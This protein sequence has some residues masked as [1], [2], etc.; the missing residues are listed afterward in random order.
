MKTKFLAFL[1]GAALVCLISGAAHAD[2]LPLPANLIGY[3]T[4][5][6]NA[7]DSSATGNNGSFSGSYAAGINGQSFNLATGSVTI[8][9]NTAYG[10]LGSG[11]SAGFRFNFNGISAS[12][13]DIIGQDVGP[14]GNPKW[15]VFYDYTTPGFEL[16]INGPSTAFLTA[17]AVPITPGWHQ[18]TVTD[19]GGNYN[20]YLDGS[21]IGSTSFGGAF[22]APSAPLEFGF[23]DGGAPFPG[24]LE[25]VVLYNVALTP[26]EVSALG[27]VPEPSTWAMMLL[28]FAGLGFMAYRRKSKPALMAA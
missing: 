28:G 10:N 26:G 11:F 9:N 18:F 17:N 4:G 23:A 7:N 13:W 24:L 19:S 22:P 21:N 25:D 27:G 2:V 8:P 6:G 3:W 5:N 12:A 14:G 20:F 15:V 16:H 1:T